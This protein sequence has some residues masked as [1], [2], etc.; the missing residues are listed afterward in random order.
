MYVDGIKK[1]FTIILLSCSQDT[2]AGPNHEL[3]ESSPCLHI[4]FLLWSLLLMSSHLSL[5]LLSGLF[6][7]GFL[8]KTDY[9]VLFFSPWICLKISDMLQVIQLN[10]LISL[11]LGDLTNEDR[12]KI[13][14][15]CTIDVHS[16][17]V[18]AKMIATKVENASAFQWQSQLRHRY[19]S[20]SYQLWPY[21]QLKLPFRLNCLITV[22]FFF[23]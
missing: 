2:S 18:V 4:L 1:S 8:T 21:K 16:R 3:D 11:L 6:F 10:T 17:D 22:I 14:T 15:I 12:Q 23:Q 19:Y 13:M 20:I 7:S 9:A 5:G